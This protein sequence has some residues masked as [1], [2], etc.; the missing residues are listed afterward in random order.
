ML[1]RKRTD[2]NTEDV[3]RYCEGNEDF[4]K[5]LDLFSA[6]YIP[7]YNK[8]K[9]K[10][11]EEVQPYLK[12]NFFTWYYSVANQVSDVSPA[13][14]INS[15]VFHKFGE[16]FVV[17]PIPEPVYKKSR[18][19]S[20]N[21][22]F[23]I[24]T[25]DD[26]PLMQDVEC[27]MGAIKQTGAI[28]QVDFAFGNAHYLSFLLNL[29]GEMGLIV[30]KESDLNVNEKKLAAFSSLPEKDKLNK[31]LSAHLGGFLNNMK[32]QPNHGKLPTLAKL[33]KVLGTSQ[34]ID[35]LF[36]K[37]FPGLMSRVTDFISPFGSM[38]LDDID[39]FHEDEDS[40][41]EMMGSTIEMQMLLSSITSAIFICCGLYFQI[42]RLEY[43]SC[44]DFE[45]LDGD[46]LASLPPKDSGFDENE[47]Q[48][49][50]SMMSFIAYIKPPSRYSVTPIG[51]KLFGKNY[52][53][54]FSYLL[55]H[56][57]EYD[58]V[59]EDML[60]DRDE[61]K[62]E[63]YDDFIMNLF[64]GSIFDFLGNVNDAKKMPGRGD[65]LQFPASQS[66]L[67][68]LN[69]DNKPTFTDETATYRFK[70]NR[71]VIAINGNDTLTDLGYSI[72][73]VFGLD[74]FH[75]SSFYMG[76]KI[77]ES[78]REIRCPEPF[79]DSGESDNYRICD[80][81]LFKGQTFMYVYDFGNERRFTIKFDGCVG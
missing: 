53:K 29:C 81:G 6:G 22:G 38:D 42:I 76:K 16:D 32:Q 47:A 15:H 70:V 54:E 9:V 1:K 68:G 18:L 64:G 7:V 17:V 44:F 13:R 60:L 39:V 80:L 10:L 33:L 27:V 40:I 50:I 57:D 12:R 35:G 67:E 46:Y 73:S 43:D 72:E 59:L 11:R 69:P 2:C 58:E 75:L 14:F 4:T 61:I 5:I 26:H 28:D 66:P 51:A 63:N 34:D 77:F 31:M 37:A 65:L 79:S 8:R 3:K 21:Y 78:S 24:F 19:L 62:S 48:Q 71:R 20:I 74:G 41:E 23:H 30:Q 56:P 52:A 45:E 55:T 49:Y 36:A 25:V